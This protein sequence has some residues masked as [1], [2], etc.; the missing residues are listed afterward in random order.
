MMVFMNSLLLLLCLL[1]RPAITAESLTVR[2]PWSRERSPPVFGFDPDRYS[3]QT[4]FPPLG[5][6]G[7]AKLAAARVAVLGCGALGSASALALALALAR[8][9]VGFARGIG[10]LGMD[11]P[12]PSTD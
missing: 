9:G 5:P 7:Q 4:R 12:T 3:R 8:A 1:S 11:T 2:E 6:A 10:L